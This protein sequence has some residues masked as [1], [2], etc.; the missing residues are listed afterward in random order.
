MDEHFYLIGLDATES[1]CKS[2]FLLGNMCIFTWPVK[3]E[4]QANM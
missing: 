1:V 3:G 2:G 4:T